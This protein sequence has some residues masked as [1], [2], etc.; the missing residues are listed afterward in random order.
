MNFAQN[1]RTEDDGPS[2]GE[3]FAFGN[4]SMG[5]LLPPVP[6]SP[7]PVYTTAEPSAPA[8]M[9]TPSSPN[10]WGFMNLEMPKEDAVPVIIDTEDDDGLAFWEDSLVGSMPIIFEDPAAEAMAVADDESSSASTSATMPPSNSAAAAFCA[11]VAFIGSTPL[12]PAIT[13]EQQAPHRTSTAAA[14]LNEAAK[15]LPIMHCQL[16]EA[17]R[18][19]SP[20]E[21]RSTPADAIPD[22][23]SPTK[24]PRR[25]VRIVR[26][27]CGRSASLV[28]AAGGGMAAMGAMG[29]VAGLASACGSS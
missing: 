25:V 13:P 20:R 11:R 12:R 19:P 14:P 15:D 3:A 1:E 21:V 5:A 2:F 9:A 26:G 10:A 24:R 8:P 22:G 27:L 7:T 29:I 23:P 17:R 16:R 28:A 18:A 6:E 4:S